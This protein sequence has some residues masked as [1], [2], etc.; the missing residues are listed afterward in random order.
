MKT[1][2]RFTAP[3]ALGL[4]LIV[5]AACVPSSTAPAAP[6]AAPAKLVPL[7]I[8]TAKGTLHYKVE[9]ALTPQEQER[10]LMF[11][12]GLPERGGMIFPM[13]PSRWA[14]FWM[15]NTLIPLDIIFIREDGHIARIA[16]N[17]AP[18]SLDLIESGEPI[19]SVLEIIG[20]GAAA[21]G[22]APGDIV[23]W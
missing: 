3:L 10:G 11:R 13:K 9:V 2:A 19:G 12:T 8:V 1:Y 15:K 17:A 6:K 20:G 22:I 7:D 18:E 21:A 5:V 14:T 4:A 23:R 16:A